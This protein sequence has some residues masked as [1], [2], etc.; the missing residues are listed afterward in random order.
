ME[1]PSQTN[2]TFAFR[3]ITSEEFRSDK[4]T[5]S[6]R[7]EIL[8][9]FEVI[10]YCKTEIFKDCILGTLRIPR[11]SS[12]KS[13]RLTFGFYLTKD[14]LT[15]ID[16]SGR[17][18]KHHK[19]MNELLTDAVSPDSCLL[20]LL[21]HLSEN[22]LFYL[23]RIEEKLDKMENTMSDQDSDQFFHSFIKIRKRLSA[24][25]AYYEQMVEIGEQMQTDICMDLIQNSTSWKN[26][27]RHMDRL[28]NY[29]HLLREYAMQMRELYQSLMDARQNRVMSLLTIITT[30]FLPLTLLTGWYGMNFAYMP[31][32]H[33][34]Y[35]YPAVILI[36][37]ILII[38][39]L[40]FF[41]KKKML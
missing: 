40:I 16:D 8:N 19:K 27:T 5:F 1:T 35:G 6:H 10:R 32:L 14:S 39:E 37:V 26:Y 22:D 34:K 21:E 17:L 13:P 41:K 11:K 36:S 24:F 15:L 33:W 20:I 3:I 4:E 31:E 28:L 18:K 38:I 2:D 30:V 29:V 25:H 7:R 12:Q 23:Q 9:G